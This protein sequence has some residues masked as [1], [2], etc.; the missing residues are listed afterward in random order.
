MND[1]NNMT[2]ETVSFKGFGEGDNVVYDFHTLSNLMGTSETTVLSSDFI[3]F[4]LNGS[5]VDLRFESCQI[6]FD[7]GNNHVLVDYIMGQS[8]DGPLVAVGNIPSD[9]FRQ[10]FETSEISNVTYAFLLFDFDESTDFNPGS[11]NLTITINAVGSQ[12]EDSNFGNSPDIESVGR[13]MYPPPEDSAIKK[14][15]MLYE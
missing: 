5:S 9:Q 1:G 2:I 6:V 3:L 4:E 15:W 10:I 8:P 13:I 12:E 7:D 14:T 11:D